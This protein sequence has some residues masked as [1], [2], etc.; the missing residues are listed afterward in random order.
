MVIFAFLIYEISALLTFEEVRF[1]N[2]FLLSLDFK[3]FDE[4]GMIVDTEKTLIIE[5]DPLTDIILYPNATFTGSQYILLFIY[6]V[7]SISL[8][9]SC[10]G[11]EIYTTENMWV[12]YSGFEIISLISNTATANI[13]EQLEI[14]YNNFWLAPFNELFLINQ[15]AFEYFLI[16]IN[17]YN[18]TAYVTFLASGVKNLLF[19]FQDQSNSMLNG[20]ALEIM[21]FQYNI[22]EFTTGNVNFI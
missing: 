7:Y 14:R 2:F 21:F 11:C 6:N 5:S 19:Y 8:K 12:Y 22:I 18:G 4:N 3:L 15:E 17:D 1:D 9:L 13:Y 10:A 16:P 20:I